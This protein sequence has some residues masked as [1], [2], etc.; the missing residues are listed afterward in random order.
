LAFVTTI[1]ATLFGG[2]LAVGSS[3]FLRRW[4]L[5][6]ATRIRM[7]DELL[8]ELAR[9]YFSWRDIHR[10]DVAVEVS[11]EVLD[12]ATKLWR[13]AE[14]VGHG[15]ADIVGPIKGLMEKRSQASNLEYAHDI[16]EQVNGQSG[17][18]EDYLRKKL[19]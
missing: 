14:I 7:F 5:R 1:I 18:L 3:V 13:A 2:V 11:K 6:Q 19:H 8:P 4:E 17:M 12:R 15:E 16:D 9:E 10:D